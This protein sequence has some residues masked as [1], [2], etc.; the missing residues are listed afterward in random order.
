MKRILMGAFLVVMLFFMNACGKGDE[1]TPSGRSTTVA[2]QDRLLE[3]R[4]VLEAELA[5]L[6][7]VD[8]TELTCYADTETSLRNSLGYNR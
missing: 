4:E 3:N 6:N 7:P 5:A 2:E 8:W 1:G